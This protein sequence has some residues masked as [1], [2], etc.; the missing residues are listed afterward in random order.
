MDFQPKVD[1]WRYAGKEDRQGRR[2]Q[3]EGRIDAHEGEIIS[4]RLSNPSSEPLDVTLLF[5]DGNF[6]IK[7]LF[8]TLSGTDNRLN[9]HESV[10]TPRLR[11]TGDTVGPE[12]VLAIAVRGKKQ[13]ERADFGFL[14]QPKIES[15]R[16][17]GT[18]TPA[19][20]RRD[21]D[22]ALGR[23]LQKGRYG[24]GQARGAALL[25]LDDYGIRLFSW[26]TLARPPLR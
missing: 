16:D 10:M 5:I 14:E 15:A 13:A 11:V 4:F 6:G 21:F 26:R 9:G 20:V 3:N 19:G 2:D 18:R 24:F 12:S 7:T 8:P 25:D 22:S 17:I 23:L 1:L